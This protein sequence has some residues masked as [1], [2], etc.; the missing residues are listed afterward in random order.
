MSGPIIEVAIAQKT[1]FG[2]DLSEG[3]D[4]AG[5]DPQGRLLHQGKKGLRIDAYI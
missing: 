5:Y 3:K 2:Y 4:C 1:E